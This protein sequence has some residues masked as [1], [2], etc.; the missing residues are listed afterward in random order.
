M[1]L[2]TYLIKD[3]CKDFKCQGDPYDK[4]MHLKLEDELKSHGQSSDN[5]QE[6]DSHLWLTSWEVLISP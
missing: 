5:L 4:T 1:N 6:A 2:F 3:D